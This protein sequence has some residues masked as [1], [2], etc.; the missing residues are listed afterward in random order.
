MKIINAAKILSVVVLIFLVGCATYI[1]NLPKDQRDAITTRVYNKDYDTV[2]K[3]VMAAFADKD[4]AARNTDKASG[5]IE[6]DYKG[7]HAGT[8]FMK[9]TA[10]VEKIDDKTTKV[11]L[12][13][14][15]K[16]VNAW[17]TGASISSAKL[18]TRAKPTFD[19]F[20]KA[21]D[22]NLK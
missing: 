4:M 5:L 14:S 6:S 22:E 21:I 19:E 10:N 11:R 1:S 12:S 3:A 13:P 20:F 15:Y 9:M 2:F 7:V 8:A 16:Q 17:N 18:T